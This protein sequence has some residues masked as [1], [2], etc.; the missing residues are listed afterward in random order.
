[1]KANPWTGERLRLASIEITQRCDNRCAYCEQPKA[2]RD[3]PLIR[4]TE[5]LDEL[6]AEGFEAVAL[7]GGEPTLH[8]NLLTLL[9]EVQRRGLRAGLTTNARDPAQV[10]ALADADLLHRFGVSAG[11]GEWQALAA[12]PRATVNLL[13]LRRGLPQV[14]DWTVESLRQHA[15]CLLLLGYKGDCPEFAPTA[16]ELS[17]AF[18]LLTGLGRRA[19]ITVAADDYT[20]RR[21]GLSDTCGERFLRVNLDGTRDD[22][23]FPACE[24]RGEMQ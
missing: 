20:Q 2:A 16:R 12:H 18:G 14:L 10:V 3:L 24:Y 23:C 21:L 15:N 1:M 17:D 6:A 11:R 13:L 5:L 22:C 19:G 9:E 4:F 7:G 8:P